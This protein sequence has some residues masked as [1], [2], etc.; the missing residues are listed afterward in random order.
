MTVA[1]PSFSSFPSRPAFQL[2]IR[3]HTSPLENR[4]A[5]IARDEWIPTSFATVRHVH[6]FKRRFPMES[7]VSV[8]SACCGGDSRSAELRRRFSAVAHAKCLFIP[9]VDSSRASTWSHFI[10]S[11]HSRVIAHAYP[12]PQ[13]VN[14]QVGVLKGGG[15]EKAQWRQSQRSEEQNRLGSQILLGEGVAFARSNSL[16]RVATAYSSFFITA[17]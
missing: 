2:T 5:S 13:R 8:Y 11:C 6:L 12:F 14:K 15:G 3:G 17:T 10:C 7:S 4:E 9:S 16:E 1:I